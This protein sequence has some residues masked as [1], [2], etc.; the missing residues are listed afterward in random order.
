LSSIPPG[1]RI[2]VGEEP[3]GALTPTTLPLPLDRSTI[4]V[5]LDR[6]GFRPYR[7]ELS[8][9]PG[10]R[11]SLNPTLAPLDQL[12]TLELDSDPP[13]ARIFLNQRATEFKTPALVKDVDA[14]RPQRIA[15]RLQGYQPWIQEVT[16]SAGG[17]TPVMAMLER[18]KERPT[19]R[20]PGTDRRPASGSARP[21]PAPGRSESATPFPRGDSGARGGAATLIL[22]TAPPDAEVFV[23]GRR[24]GEVPLRL[25]LPTGSHRVEFVSLD[26]IKRKETVV[27]LREGENRK[28]I[29]DFQEEIWKA[30]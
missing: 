4:T 25:V 28:V 21:V 19:A 29:W 9:S 17:T 8:Y 12:G 30:K 10:Q 20:E 13:G 6:E 23:D 14:S 2:T 1:A 7:Q 3:L 24:M 22:N 27:E 26:G 5:Q 16:L 11:L 15:L 18:E